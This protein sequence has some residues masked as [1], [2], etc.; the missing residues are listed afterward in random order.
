MS[1]IVACDSGTSA[2][3]KNPCSRRNA[4]ICSIEAAMPQSIDAIVKPA[5]ETR[6]TFFRPN[7]LASQPEGAVMIAAAMT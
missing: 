3:P 4:T 5:T 6:N 7:R 2:A 1:S